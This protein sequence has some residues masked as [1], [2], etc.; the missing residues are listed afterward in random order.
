[1]TGAGFRDRAVSPNDET[2]LPPELEEDFARDVL[3]KT[4]RELFPFIGYGLYLPKY[5]VF[6]DLATYGQ[7]ESVR[8]G[9]R[10]SAVMEFP[11][12]A[13]GSSTDSYVPYGELGYVW[14]QW[15]ALFELALKPSARLEDG[16]VADQLLE[17]L[18]RGATPSFLLGRFVMGLKWEVRRADTSKTNVSLGGDNGLR[19]YKSKVIQF[20]GSDDFI[21][22]NIEYRTP[23]LKWKS[24]HLGLVLF[25]DVGSVYQRL[26]RIKLFHDAGIGLRMLFPQFHSYL[27]RLDFGVP[28]NKVPKPSSN[29]VIMVSFGSPQAV[30]LHADEDAEVAT[31]N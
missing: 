25:Y 17:M 10:L 23:P 7:S 24:V 29:A 14:A 20:K 16:R 27:F 26:D 2:N 13:F 4:R 8:I 30:T 5:V 11:L 31:D 3:P 19:G 22:G 1:M 9:P 6:E 18:A 21:L 28:F 12:R 15:D